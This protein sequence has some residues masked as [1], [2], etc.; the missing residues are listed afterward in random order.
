MAPADVATI[1]Y[2]SGTTGRPKGVVLTQSNF[3]HQLRVLPRALEIADEE[4]FLSLLP[5]WHIFE[6]IVE[7]VALTNG[8]RLVYTD[9][10]RFQWSLLALTHRAGRVQGL[11]PC[12]LLRGIRQLGVP[13]R[14]RALE[15]RHRRLLGA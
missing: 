6:R 10:R 4:V 2:T 3:G 13:L 1:I 11:G 9:Q 12:Q 15:R 7:Y 8:C 5:P 14:A